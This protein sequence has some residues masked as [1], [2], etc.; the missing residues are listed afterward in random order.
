[1][2]KRSKRWKGSKSEGPHDG[3]MEQVPNLLGCFVGFMHRHHRQ[4]RAILADY[5]DTALQRSAYANAGIRLDFLTVNLYT[6]RH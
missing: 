5:S 6:D 1:M 4:L 3:A 2:S